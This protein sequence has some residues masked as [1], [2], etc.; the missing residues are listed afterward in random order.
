[1]DGYAVRSGDVETRRPRLR[2][3][4]TLMAGDDPGTLVVGEGEAVRIMTGAVLP[5][6]ADAVCMVEH[7]RSEDGFVVIDEA[8]G[9]GTNVRLAGG[10]IAPGDR[11]FRCRRAAEP[12]SHRR[13]R[14]PWHGRGP[15]VPPAPGGRYL[16]RRR[17]GGRARPLAPE[18]P[19]QQPARAPGPIEGRRLRAGRPRPVRD[20]PVPLAQTL[21]GGGCRAATPCS[22]AAGSASATGTS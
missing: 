12:G 18:D 14:K 22:P 11:G 1:M 7:T 8:V 21:Q 5:P 17:T 16:H 15:G 19:G 2:V 13:A 9:P 4:R 3:S 20:E 10:D 6:G